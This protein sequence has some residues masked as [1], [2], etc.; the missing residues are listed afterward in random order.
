ME[1]KINIWIGL[2]IVFTTMSCA[3][4]K[5]S[6][7]KLLGNYVQDK[8]PNIELQFSKNQFV[9]IDTYEQKHLPP[10]KC[11]DTLAYGSWKIE[12]EGFLRLSS[13][14][15]LNTYFIYMEVTEELSNVDSLYFYFDNPIEGHYK[16]FGEKRRELFY[17][18]SAETNNTEL[19]VVLSK[20][21]DINPIVVPNPK[22]SKI[23]KFYIE[24]IPKSDLPVRELNTLYASTLEYEIQNEN[25]NVFR[26]QLP[27]LSYQYLAYKRLNE[28][29]VKI[30]NSK[31]L[32]WDGNVYTKK[33]L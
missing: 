21:I 30:E 32:R 1:T 3:A 2:F 24:I 4:Q 9:L 33:G 25:S 27:Q 22:K 26:I 17:S 28:D 19:M 15:E 31:K 11:C 6:S 5:I 13:P 10:F 8:N 14:E 12:K 18:I 29:F 20:N 23:S 16:K 7:T